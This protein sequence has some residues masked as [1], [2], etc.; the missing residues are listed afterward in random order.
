M[1]ACC[2][3]KSRELAALR[4][5]QA[6]VVAIALGLNACMFL[7]EFAGGLWAGSTALLGDSLDMLGDSFVYAFTL[8]VL[9]R[10]A[11]WRARAALAK[12]LVMGAFGLGVLFE[13]GRS[14]LLG[15]VPV[16][17]T[18]GAIGALALAANL[19][20]FLL[21]WRHRSDDLN[22]RSTWLCSRNDI[23]GNAAVL[24]SAAAVA[25]VGSNW[26]DVLVGAAI[27]VLF[28]RSAAQVLGSALGEATGRGAPREVSR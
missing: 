24:A 8:F 7:V 1:D 6:R 25:R 23:I 3:D 27:A 26:P 28:L 16:A 17:T 15:S 5:R 19:A 4:G 9:E 12:G 20:C 13:A 2:E 18:M 10:S 21:L 11:A 22:M 14:L